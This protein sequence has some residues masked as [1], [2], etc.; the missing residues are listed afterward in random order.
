MSSDHLLR[1]GRRHAAVVSFA[2]VSRVECQVQLA[3]AFVEAE[4]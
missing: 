1:T 4:F 3:I 2:S